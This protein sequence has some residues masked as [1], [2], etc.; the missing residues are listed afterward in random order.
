MS[1]SYGYFDADVN[2]HKP[3]GAELAIF[4]VSATIECR[5]I[6]VGVRTSDILTVLGS[7]REMLDF[8]ANEQSN[9]A[10]V[11]FGSEFLDKQAGMDGFDTW[12][13]YV[14]EKKA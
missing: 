3:N 4:D 1:K 5:W 9:G 8:V 7:T 14:N 12:A 6:A 11:V 13:E 10:K 2:L